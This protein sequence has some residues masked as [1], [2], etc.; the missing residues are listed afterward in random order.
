MGGCFSGLL[1]PKRNFPY[2]KFVA[3]WSLVELFPLPGKRCCWSGN[4]LNQHQ[5]LYRGQMKTVGVF[6]PMCDSL[7]Q[8]DLRLSEDH[9]TASGLELGCQCEGQPV[10]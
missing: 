1:N 3:I 7:L 6:F 9:L 8:R 5:V 10:C 4:Q 2:K